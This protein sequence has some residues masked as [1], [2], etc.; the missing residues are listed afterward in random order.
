MSDQQDNTGTGFEDFED[1]MKH[2]KI[3]RQ[4]SNIPDRIGLMGYF[5]DEKRSAFLQID[6]DHRLVLS[7]GTPLY[8]ARLPVLLTNSAAIVEAAPTDGHNRLVVGIDILNYTSS[9]CRGALYMSETTPGVDQLFGIAGEQIL[10]YSLWSWR[11]QIE[12]DA[13]T[14]IW[15]WAEAV[16]TL[17]AFFMVRY[18]GNFVRD[19]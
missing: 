3:T 18:A 1:F 12:L 9:V 19:T 16:S 8:D 4:A 5:Y 7:P 2:F 15:G 13:T 11:G 14:N 17:R 10:P 6:S